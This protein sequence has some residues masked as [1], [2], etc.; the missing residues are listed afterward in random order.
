[1]NEV[2]IIVDGYN[3]IRQWPELAMLDR[4]D[5]QSG[6][7]ALLSELRVYRRIRGHRITVVFDGREQGGFSESGE[8][9]GG[10]GVRYSKRGETAD[11]VIARLLAEGREGAVVV[12]SDREILG[13]ARRYGAASLGAAEFMAKVEAT[14]IASLKGGEEEERPGKPGKGTA[15]RLPKAERRMQRRL[16]AL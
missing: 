2:W 14:R 6:R 5:L 4:A 1:L 8:S 13:A 12:S 11:A 10:I 3:L 15:R 16:K 7:E 9:V